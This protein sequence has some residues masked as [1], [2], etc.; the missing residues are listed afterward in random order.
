MM[1]LRMITQSNLTVRSRNESSSSHPIAL[2]IELY[3]QKI[4]L[5]HVPVRHIMVLA[6][7]HAAV[8]VQ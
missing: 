4:A 3:H 7:E 1:G 2:G 5:K 6:I 8:Q